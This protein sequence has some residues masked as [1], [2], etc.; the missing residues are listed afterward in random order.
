MSTVLEAVQTFFVLLRE[1]QTSQLDPWLERATGSGVRE[2][3]AFAEGVRRRR[4]PKAFAVTMRRFARPATCRGAKD[5]PK[6]KSTDSSC[7]SGRCM[8]APSW[9][10]SV[11]AY[12]VGT[13]HDMPT[14]Q[15]HAPGRLLSCHAKCGRPRH[16]TYTEAT[17]EPWEIGATFL[18]AALPDAVTP[19]QAWLEPYWQVGCANKQTRTL[20]AA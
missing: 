6:A 2:L 11:S 20:C 19:Q 14:W 18:F 10:Y 16:W 5:R 15:A 17:I 4:S 3:A 8:V 1:R 13:L 7:L 12:S 9:I